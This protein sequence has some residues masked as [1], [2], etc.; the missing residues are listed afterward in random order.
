MPGLVSIS[1]HISRA[2]FLGQVAKVG[3]S[4][5]V[6]RLEPS[7]SPP[8]SYQSQRPLRWTTPRPESW[9]TEVTDSSPVGVVVDFD[10]TA[11]VL[12]FVAIT[13]HVRL[14]PS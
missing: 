5:L 9:E 13:T 2:Y 1:T 7:V 11:D 12:S 10:D 8:A 4:F 6:S 14:E 3:D